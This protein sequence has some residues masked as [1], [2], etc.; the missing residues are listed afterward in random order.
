[1]GGKLIAGL[2]KVQKQSGLYWL[3]AHTN[4]H[5]EPSLYSKLLQRKDTV[6]Y[7]LQNS[8]SNSELLIFWVSGLDDRQGPG[9][10][11]STYVLM[12]WEHVRAL[13]YHI[14]ISY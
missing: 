4:F 9:I 1:M 14:K 13:P 7:E 8:D 5:K 11:Q 6:G 3:V 12:A 2:K 10:Q